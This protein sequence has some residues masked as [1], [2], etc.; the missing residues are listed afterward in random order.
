MR[1]LSR[2]GFLVVGVL[3]LIS[4]AGDATVITVGSP[5][6]VLDC[7]RGEIPRS[8]EALVSGDSEQQAVERALV[9]WLEDGASLANPTEAEVWSAVVEGNEIA[10]A[11]PE[12]EGDGGWVV[13]DV[14]ICEEPE[15]GPAEIDGSI[16]CPGDTFWT[17][18]AM[19]DTE[20][21]GEDTPE[22][23][24]RLGLEPYAERNGGEIMMIDESTGSL[25]VDEREQVV[26]YADEAPAG[27]WVATTMT[28]CG[29]ISG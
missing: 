2:L 10:I 19:L 25:V 8:T 18:Q 15:S 24:V 3:T 14:R 4:C 11:V 12:Q 23:A 26:A 28:G 7:G 20:T 22:E 21:P 9:T 29:E 27:G 5:D 16:D 17:Q 1:H 6:G 13:A